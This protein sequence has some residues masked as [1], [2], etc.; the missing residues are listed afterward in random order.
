FINTGR[1][2]LFIL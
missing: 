1:W 2:S